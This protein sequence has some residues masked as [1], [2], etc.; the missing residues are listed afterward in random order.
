MSDKRSDRQ[1]SLPPAPGH[2][3]PSLDPYEIEFRQ[4]YRE[5]RGPEAP[6]VND[7]GVVIGDHDY[8]S[9][10]SPLEQWTEETDPHTMSGDQWVHPFKD[11]GFRT[12][13]NRDLF[14]TG[15]APASGVFMHPAIQSAKPERSCYDAYG[16]EDEY[17]RGYFPIPEVLDEP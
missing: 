15:I 5:G 14:E 8:A 17:E 12:R 11:V 4:E 6:F 16:D 13:E 3:D 7:Y 1:R 9:P 2:D 10:N